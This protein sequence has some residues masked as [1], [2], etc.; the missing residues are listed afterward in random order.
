MQYLHTKSN[1]LYNFNG[2]VLLEGGPT[3]GVS[4]SP[5]Y[6][7]DVVWVRPAA[8][9]FDGRF[10]P[11]FG[12]QTKIT[13]AMEMG[14]SAGDIMTLEEGIQMVDDFIRALG[15]SGFTADLSVWAPNGELVR[16]EDEMTAD[17]SSVAFRAGN[18]HT[19]EV[20]VD[21]NVN[22]KV[23]TSDAV[24]EDL[25]VELDQKDNS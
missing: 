5:L 25:P 23:P 1:G 17:L 3:I 18:I 15:R 14:D 7:D 12:N 19:V 2:L 22:Y 8:E 20:D 24:R 6:Q 9:F 4:Y 10:V 11:F 13:P 21:P 16:S